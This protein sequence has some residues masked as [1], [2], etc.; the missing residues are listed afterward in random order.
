[1]FDNVKNLTP[2]DLTKQ[3]LKCS[4]CFLRAWRPQLLHHLQTITSQRYTIKTLIS[5]HAPKI[6]SHC[7][8]VYTPQCWDEL[9]SQ[10]S[11]SSL[12]LYVSMQPAPWPNF[13][14]YEPFTPVKQTKKSMFNSAALVIQMYLKCVLRS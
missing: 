12:T 10:L 1:M 7:Y 5:R 14:I 4:F 2:A 8:S 3:T 11:I 9:L 6:Q 13:F